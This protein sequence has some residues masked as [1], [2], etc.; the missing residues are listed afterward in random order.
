MSLVSENLGFPSSGASSGGHRPPLQVEQPAAA[1]LMIRRDA[2]D[3]VGDFDEQFYPAWYE[4]V[5]FCQRLK[6]KGW[7]VYFVSKAQFL[8]EGGYSVEAMGATDFL[9]SYYTNQLRYARKH[10]GVLGAAVVRTSIVAG[11]IARMIGKP[12]QAANYGRSLIAILRK[13]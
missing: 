1:A 9:N 5:D 10:F 12:R 13:Q 6:T 7:E 3:D 2:Y 4:D 11:M 8:H